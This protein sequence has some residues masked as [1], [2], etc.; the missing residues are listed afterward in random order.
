[1]TY[2]KRIN[3]EVV[4]A[5][6]ENGG[7]ENGLGGGVNDFFLGSHKSIYDSLKRSLVDIFI[8]TD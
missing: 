7:D 8:F 5:A 1:M 3:A 2:K 4:A 6:A